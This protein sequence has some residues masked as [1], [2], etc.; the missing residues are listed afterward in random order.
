MRHVRGRTVTTRSESSDEFH[1]PPSGD[2]A[3]ASADLAWNYFA[4]RRSE[5]A[6]LNAAVDAALQK[7]PSITLITGEAGIGKTRL[8][9]EVAK[10]SRERGMTFMRGR[11]FES[12]SAD[13]YFPFLEIFRQY[14]LL[15]PHSPDI[16][17]DKSGDDVVS[18]TVLLPDVATELPDEQS[19]P[20]VRHKH[21]LI[22]DG[23]SSLLTKISAAT[24]LLLAIED[25]QFADQESLALLLH[26]ERRLEGGPFLILGTC[27]ERTSAK[28]EAFANFIHEVRTGFAVRSISLNGFSEGEVA[29]LFEGIT[30]C[31]VDKYSGGLTTEIQRVSGGNASFAQQ[32]IHELIEEVYLSFPGSVTDP[33]GTGDPSKFPA[34]HRMVGLRLA[35]LDPLLRRLLGEA[36]VLGEAFEL[37]VLTAMTGVPRGALGEAL[38]GALAARMLV[39]SGSK[40]RSD[41]RFVHP[42]IQQQ[43]Y[44]SH[45]LMQRRELHGRAADALASVKHANLT[46]YFARLARHC[47]QSATPQNLQRAV[48]YFMQAGEA[49]YRV[50]SFGEASG[51][52]RSAYEIAQMTGASKATAARVLERRA[53]AA[54]LSSST[55]GEA[56]GFL[57]DA[58]RLYEDAGMLQETASVHA[59]L[60]I[61]LSMT[62]SSIAIGR[63][64]EHSIE[65]V[66]LLDQ[67]CCDQSLAELRVSQSLAAH[68]TFRTQDG[69]TASSD[70]M[71]IAREINNAEL[72]C[73]AG[74]LHGLLLWACGELRA[75][76]ILFDEV[77]ERS[78]RARGAKAAFASAWARGYCSLLLMDP[79]TAQSEF[80]EGLR[81]NSIAAS[82]FTRQVLRANCGIA[83]T[84]A[85]DLPKA[86]ELL[87]GTQ[88]HFLEANIRF[89]E[90]DLDASEILL[91]EELGRARDCR[92]AQLEWAYTLWLARVYRVRQE[93]AL[94]EKLLVN[95]SVL[96]EEVVRR[97][98]EIWTR[99]ELALLYAQTDRCG[100][101]D[102]QVGRCKD[103]MTGEIEEWRGLAGCVD[104]AAAVVRGAQGRV[105]ES[106]YCYGKTLDT[107]GRYRLKWETAETLI[108]WSQQLINGN[109]VS[110]GI[111]KLNQA[112]LTYSEIGAGGYWVQRAQALKTSLASRPLAPIEA[113]NSEQLKAG[114]ATSKFAGLYS[115][116][117]EYSKATGQRP[118]DEIYSYATIQDVALLGTFIHDAIAHLMGAIDKTSRLREPVDRLVDSVERM[119]LNLERLVRE[120]VKK[121]SRGRR[122]E[123]K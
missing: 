81:A 43:L 88:H 79:G 95:S 2:I 54:F 78:L 7:H 13:S 34:L 123:P 105:E 119:S 14:F 59:R 52:W 5:L 98:E 12:H 110:A 87:E 17:F 55:P 121:G 66:G 19:T 20:V 29:E 63:A 36:A 8:V 49:A 27:R 72:W 102:A 15:H 58:L 44:E 104:R 120:Q 91:R 96:K 1:S 37:D 33:D 50:Y 39:E 92:C 84:L 24:P 103:L 109:E 56:A 53:E 118:Q 65:A 23:L 51:Y 67:N 76:A 117:A 99:A 40:D 69:L 64:A 74:A 38:N 22:V 85:G 112:E 30:Q 16:G 62:S 93:F 42:L 114:R 61:I 71:R 115:L 83:C 101:A 46:P 3:R 41:Y 60:A 35:Q 45:S 6:V 80:F 86:R 111:E 21:R 116:A 26:L 47:E 9:D 57:Q 11:C 100:L 113:G 73:E 75:A 107:L 10:Y 48:E 122:S 108:I 89:I 94:A 106:E 31:P 68:A 97:P 90:G 28:N 18:L 4:G 25:L 70:A 32:L 77:A 82:D